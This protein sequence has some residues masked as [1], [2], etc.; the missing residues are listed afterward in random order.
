[1]LTFRFTNVQSLYSDYFYETIKTSK[2]EDQYKEFLSIF[3][4]LIFQF[5]KYK[6]IFLHFVDII[7]MLKK[8]LILTWSDL[9]FELTNLIDKPNFFSIFI[10]NILNRS[11]NILNIYV[12]NYKGSVKL[13]MIGKKLM[14]IINNLEQIRKLI[15]D[16]ENLRKNLVYLCDQFIYFSQFKKYFGS[17]RNETFKRIHF[18]DDRI[19]HTIKNHL[20]FVNEHRQSS[21]TSHFICL[22]ST[23]NLM[24]KLFISFFNRIYDLDLEK[25]GDNENWEKIIFLFKHI[26]CKAKIF[27]LF[28][29]KM[30]TER[31]CKRFFDQMMNFG[32]KLDSTTLID[33]L[34]AGL[35]DFYR[36]HIINS[37]N[38]KLGPL[39]SNQSI[40]NYTNVIKSHFI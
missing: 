38:K 34:Q 1:M 21:E 13:E 18:T 5:V 10:E 28:V 26:E 36:L 35:F 22:P 29:K 25:L 3:S 8:S 7:N 27:R 9:N 2:E 30:T 16:F 12:N 24:I 6:P 39:Y 20:E 19:F 15:G 40:I 17:I 37:E 4:D 14:L 23:Q 31:D 32:N 11:E 33:D